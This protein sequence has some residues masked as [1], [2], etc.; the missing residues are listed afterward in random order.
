[1]TFRSF[2]LGKENNHDITATINTA[3][4]VVT[5][6]H[7]VLSPSFVRISVGTAIINHIVAGHSRSTVRVCIRELTA[8]VVI[9]T[10]SG[11]RRY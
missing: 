8:A 4:V 11:I 7:I 10:V 1:M 3:A 2:L 9:L 5:T 6:S